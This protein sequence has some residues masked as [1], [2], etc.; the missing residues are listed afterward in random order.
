[1]SAVAAEAATAAA[2]APP[3]TEVPPPE[4]AAMRALIQVM[5]R[6][7][8][9]A[10][11]SGEV[12]V[13]S[14]LATLRG[15]AAALGF[16]SDAVGLAGFLQYEADAMAALD[17]ARREAGLGGLLRRVADGWPSLSG[18]LSLADVA[19]SRPYYDPSEELGPSALLAVRVRNAVA[20]VEGSMGGR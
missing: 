7:R 2:A 4:D 5:H 13:P 3:G 17:R 10:Q 16:S 6:I 19:A 12:N 18:K 14:T 8:A 1:M 20:R 15:E 9:D 11:A